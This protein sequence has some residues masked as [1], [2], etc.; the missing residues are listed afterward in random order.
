VYEQNVLKYAGLFKAKIVL[1][2]LASK[3]DH[4]SS[5]QIVKQLTKYTK[6]NCSKISFVSSFL[7]QISHKWLGHSLAS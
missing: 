2:M 3:P 5:K 7:H 4:A 6:P 1:A